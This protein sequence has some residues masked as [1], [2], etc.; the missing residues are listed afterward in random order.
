MDG[1]FGTG[2]S[3][4]LSYAGMLLR[5]EAA[6]WERDIPGLDRVLQQAFEGRRVLVVPFSAM[7]RP[8]DLR[9]GLYQAV[10]P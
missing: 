7:E 9:L 4:F 6:A 10:A 1:S 5:G 8:D 3:H 2:K